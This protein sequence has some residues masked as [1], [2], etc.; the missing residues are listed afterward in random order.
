LK[1][2]EGRRGFA[3]GE[4]V[5][6]FG[7]GLLGYDGWWMVGGVIYLIMEDRDGYVVLLPCGAM[8]KDCFCEDEVSIIAFQGLMSY[9]SLLQP[10]EAKY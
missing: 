10:R 5:G 4:G 7:H 9:Y 3:P 8:A 6:W 2:G 1:G